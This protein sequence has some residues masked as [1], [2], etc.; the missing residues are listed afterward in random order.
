M[1]EQ[2]Q[3][4]YEN[5][6]FLEP[7]LNAV[8]LHNVCKNRLK[9]WGNEEQITAYGHS[10]NK[11]AYPYI[12]KNYENQRIIALGL[13]LRGFGGVESI[14]GLVGDLKYHLKD[15]KKENYGTIFFHLVFMYSEIL[16]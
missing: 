3:Q 7:N 16:Y 1:E 2:L 6:K 10:Y 13:N 15:G 5:E 12:G 9:C 14:K 4:L 8:C 11:I